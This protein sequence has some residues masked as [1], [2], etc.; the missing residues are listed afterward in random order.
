MSKPYRLLS[1]T[2]KDAVAIRDV[3]DRMEDAKYDRFVDE[4]I[5]ALLNDLDD[6]GNRLQEY[7]DSLAPEKIWT[8]P[9]GATTYGTIKN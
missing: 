5:N 1:L 8:P 6:N 7:L 9:E 3:V 2:R 4:V